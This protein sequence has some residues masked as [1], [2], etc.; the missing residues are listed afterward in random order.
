MARILRP[1]KTVVMA[2]WDWDSQ[3][4]DG[5]DKALVRRL[6]HAFADWQQDWTDDAD[7]WMGRRLWG[8]FSA[9]GLFDGEIHA[10]VLT[11]TAYAPSSYG[12][13]RTHDFR[14]LVERGMVAA[15][16]YERFIADQEALNAQ[17][18]YFYSLTGYVYVGRRTT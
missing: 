7:G 11:N 2:H 8:L 16:D 15:D 17:G 4:F 5:T 14:S 1:G 18:S 9:T 13:A 6:V 10:R 12:H 3:V